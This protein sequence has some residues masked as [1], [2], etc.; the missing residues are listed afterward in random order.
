M[1]NEKRLMGGALTRFIKRAMSMAFE[2][3]QFEAEEMKRQQQ[4]LR[5]GLMRMIMRKLAQ[6]FG[7]WRDEANAGKRQQDL[8]RKSMGRW[9]NQKMSAAFSSWRQ[10]L[11][12]LQAQRANMRRSLLR[13]INQK[14]SAGFQAWRARNEELNAQRDNMR[15]ALM[16]WAKQKLSRAFQ[17]WRVTTEKAS[18]VNPFE[19]A[20]RY[21]LNSSKAKCFNQWRR[22]A[23]ALTAQDKRRQALEDEMDARMKDTANA[24]AAA[25]AR[26][27]E[28]ENQ[29]PKV[30][31]NTDE[32]D[33][34]RARI[35]ELEKRP[36][37][38]NKD[39][40][41]RLK[42][43]I[44][45][46]EDLLRELKGL[47]SGELDELLR[48]LEAEKKKKE[49]Y[50]DKSRKLGM[51]VKEEKDTRTQAEKDRDLIA[52]D[53]EKERKWR[54]RLQEELA[55]LK[56]K[57]SQDERDRLA[58]LERDRLRREQEER[59]RL[60]RE[61][62]AA[63][64]RVDDEDSKA[65]MASILK[66]WMNRYLSRGFNTLRDSAAVRRRQV[67][68]IK[69]ITMKWKGDKVMAMFNKWRDYAEAKRIKEL[70]F[71][72]YLV[73]QNTRSPKSRT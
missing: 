28:L 17:K 32:L 61:R 13:W 44:R 18:K 40:L 51:E 15:R 38:D 62:D 70:E 59:D 29:K 56:A 12:E 41:R 27:K 3:W 57:M 49:D 21:F 23:A 42:E 45:E 73:N 72:A 34:L 6:A 66:H 48:K 16:R 5:R 8:L 19:R 50:M 9:R 39:E 11:E 25:Y 67:Q 54:I 1:K 33:R 55:A 65:K 35:R 2:K 52:R 20:A 58:Q 10:W 63:N 68:I 31:D 69:R 36:T 22:V 37:D 26:I 7:W 47:K 43:R 46:L 53:E 4:L 60:A 71:Q 64:R 14:L 30:I 24:L